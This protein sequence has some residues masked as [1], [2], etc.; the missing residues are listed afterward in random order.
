MFLFFIWTFLFWNTQTPSIEINFPR[1]SGS[2]FLTTW[3]APTTPSCAPWSTASTPPPSR[4]PAA[5]PRTSHQYPCSTWTRTGSRSSKTTRYSSE[6][7]TKCGFFL[8]KF[9]LPFQNM[10]VEG[11]GCRWSGVYNAARGEL[12]PE[13]RASLL[14]LLLHMQR[15]CQEEIN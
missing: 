7:P 5:S 15:F 13:T 11:C 4:P 1:I 6:F 3:T 9:L 14:L 10:V 2:P 12:G 8:N